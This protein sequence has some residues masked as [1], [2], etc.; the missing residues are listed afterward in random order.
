MTYLFL[1]FSFLAFSCEQTVTG[2]LSEDDDGTLLNLNL[3]CENTQHKKV[4]LY[5]DET[6]KLNDVVSSSIPFP[7]SDLY[8]R[9][10]SESSAQ[11][12]L[13]NRTNKILSSVDDRYV[14]FNFNK[15]TTIGILKTAA[16]GVDPYRGTYKIPLETTTFK[17]SFPK[18]K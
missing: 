10:F 7:T 1:L 4:C 6:G 14:E 17:C 11:I 5:Q 18:Q 12:H 15:K 9:E 8:E 3:V 16:V 13:L 2:Y